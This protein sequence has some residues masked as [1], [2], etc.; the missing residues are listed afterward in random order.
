M[1]V[2]RISEIGGEAFVFPAVDNLMLSARIYPGR[3]SGAATVLCLHGLTRNGKDFDTLARRLSDRFQVVAPDQRGRGR[4]AYDPDPANYNL[5][6]QS[7]DMWTLL[8]MLE[9]QRAAIVGTSMGALM[10]VVMANQQPDR[11][12]GLV[13]NDA[14]PEVDP[15]GLARIRGYVG[16]TSA[17]GDWDAAADAVSSL[18]STSYPTY[19]P[20]DWTRMARATFIETGD[21][22][23]LD[24]DPNLTAALDPNAVPPDMWPAF[25]VLK[26]I[27]T[28]VIRGAL[29]DILSAATVDRLVEQTGAR[30]VTV[31][32]R[33][34]APDLSEAESIA[35]ID[36]FLASS[37]VR[38]RFGQ[39]VVASD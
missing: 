5:F 12:A 21:E 31:P 28:L 7:R 16:K 34:H 15:E 8:D 6:T 14:G 37:E 36:A 13:L 29:S 32:D 10:G 2:A 11:I 19:G 38:A 17:V 39:A 3:E 20:E 33:G 35:A 30:T 25:A 1:T 23:R 22:L 18:H 27:P 26:T 24:Y 4:S 9:I